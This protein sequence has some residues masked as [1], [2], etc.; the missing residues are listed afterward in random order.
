MNSLIKLIQYP[1]FRSFF[2]I[3]LW[4]NSLQSEDC[5]ALRGGQLNGIS[6]A[7][8]NPLAADAVEELWWTHICLL[9]G[10]QYARFT[11]RRP[12]SVHHKGFTA[13]FSYFKGYAA[14]IFSGRYQQG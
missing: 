11:Q 1:R 7:E 10:S 12:E 13:T 14:M 5:P 9:L 3:V 4:V 8:L 6:G 2:L